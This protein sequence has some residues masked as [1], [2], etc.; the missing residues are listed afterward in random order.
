MLCL[1]ECVLNARHTLCALCGVWPIWICYSVRR[2]AHISINR[3]HLSCNLRVRHFSSWENNNLR[4][5]TLGSAL[6]DVWRLRG[7]LS[8]TKIK[9]K[10]LWYSRSNC[11]SVA[12]ILR[13]N[14]K[15][16][17]FT[18]ERCVPFSRRTQNRQRTTMNAK[19]EQFNWITN[20]RRLCARYQRIHTRQPLFLL[21]VA[22][23]TKFI[24]FV[25]RHE[26]EMEK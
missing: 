6:F 10:F 24:R 26:D 25:E 9:R 8:L 16:N 20:G 18:T 14:A 2:C 23:D 15:R 19:S 3:T 1:T 4:A 11:S 13:S 5:R 12:T 22:I 21:S 17:V 7:T